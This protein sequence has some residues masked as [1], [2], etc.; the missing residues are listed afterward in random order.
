LGW[1]PGVLALADGAGQHGRAN[2][3]GGHEV[4]VQLGDIAA[5][6]AALRLAKWIKFPTF[7]ERHA[8]LAT[9]YA[10]G[11]MAAYW[12]VERLARTGAVFDP[13]PLVADGQSGHQ[14]ADNA[15]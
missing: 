2:A 7:V 12:F 1:N 4:S 5:V 10:I 14:P 8:R 9:T 11:I 3:A 13:R 15:R 6:L